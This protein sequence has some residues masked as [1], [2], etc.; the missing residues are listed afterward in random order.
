MSSLFMKSFGGAL[1]FRL[2]GIFLEAER[3]FL[4]SEGN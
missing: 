4:R 3:F 2:V 1:D